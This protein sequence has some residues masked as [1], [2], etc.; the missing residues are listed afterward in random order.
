MIESVRM[1]S[2]IL[3]IEPYPDD[4]KK[5]TASYWLETGVKLAEFEVVRCDEK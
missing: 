4:D 3:I 1:V 5:A 2:T